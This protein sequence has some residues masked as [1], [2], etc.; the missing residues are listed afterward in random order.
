MVARLPG[1]VGTG[2]NEDESSNGRIW[3]AG[4]HHVTALSRLARVFKPMK[5]LFL[6][7]SKF[8]FSGRD[9]PRILNPR[10]VIYI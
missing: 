5:R 10:K 8:F 4:F 1:S 6:Q 2:T 3:T 9:Q 7:F